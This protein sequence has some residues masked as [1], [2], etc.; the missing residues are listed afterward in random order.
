MALGGAA[1]GT[2]AGIL[3]GAVVG[4]VLSVLK[5]T[6]AYGL[7]STLI[8]GG[9]GACIGAVAGLVLD[10]RDRS[11]AAEVGTVIS[12]EDERRP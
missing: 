5:E 3:L 7:D 2:L 1:C 12:S 4:V 8:G 9:I 6:W 11:E 10:S